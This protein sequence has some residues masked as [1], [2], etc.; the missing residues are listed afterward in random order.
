MFNNISYKKKF[1]ALIM[2]GVVLS[3]SAYKRSFSLTID[4]YKESKSLIERLDYINVSSNSVSILDKEIQFLN[5]LIGEDNIE[6][7]LVQQE[8]L[9]FVT[10]SSPSVSVINIEEVHSAIDNDF[11]I[12]SNQLTLEGAFEDL[13]ETVYSFEKEFVYSRLVNVSFFKKKDFKTRK[14]KLYSKIIFQNYEKSV[15]NN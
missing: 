3:I 15:Q 2:I 7:E 5:N 4:S 1:F 11:N 12:Y 6:P 13:L 14:E 10:N 8:I 9:N